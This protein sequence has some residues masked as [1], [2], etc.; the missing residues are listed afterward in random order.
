MTQY[1]YIASPIK[2]P[3]G[4][5]GLTPVSLERPN[6]F[7]NEL[8]FTHL[9]FEDNI[10]NR[11]KK[12]ISFSPHF[13]FEYQVDTS[14]NFMP[15]KGSE[16]GHPNE[17]KCLHILYCYLDEALH[18]SGIVEIFTCV[19]GDEHR[20]INSKKQVKWKDIQSPYDLVMMDREFWVI[21]LN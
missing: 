10:E 18:D 3:V 7:R 11:S 2:L 12:R 17:E 14:H 4:S 13:S 6:V 21:H 15:L 19:S 16:T 8:D 20:A 1:W 9:Y 5:Y